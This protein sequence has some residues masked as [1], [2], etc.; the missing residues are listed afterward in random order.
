MLLQSLFLPKLSYLKMKK[1]LPLLILIL[2][3]CSLFEDT[4]LVDVKEIIGPCTIVL[5]DGTSVVSSGNIEISKSELTITYRDEAGKLWSLFKDNY[6]S[7]S[8][9]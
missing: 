8:C 2:A 1:Y 4:K 3:S 5:T 6:T 7:Y 9:Q